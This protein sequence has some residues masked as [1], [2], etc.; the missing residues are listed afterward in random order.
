MEGWCC[1]HAHKQQRRPTYA[2]QVGQKNRTSGRNL[3]T[4]GLLANY[5]THSSTVD[6][7]PRSSNK[8]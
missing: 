4:D 6:L 7:I 1:M 5:P 2:C 3:Y 8:N